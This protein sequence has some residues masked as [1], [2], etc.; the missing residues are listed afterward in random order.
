MKH[1]HSRLLVATFAALATVIAVPTWAQNIAVVN[2]RP[3]PKAKA[4]EIIQQ[5]TKQGQADTPELEAK[6]KESLITRELLMQEIDK[7]GLIGDK[8]VQDKLEQ[9]R[10]QILIQALAQSYFKANPPSDA[11]ARVA[12]DTMAK[13]MSPKEY[14]A[15]HI[16]VEKESEAKAIIAK[17]K[18]GAKFEDLAKQ[19]KDPG[20]AANGGDLDWAP[21]NNYVAPFS[22]ALVKLQKGHYT[23]TPVKTQFGWH[24]IRLDDV[25]DAK[26]PTFEEAKPQVVQ[27]M[28]Q[29]QRWEQAKFAEFVESLKAKAKIE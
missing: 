23:E 6:V 13:S 21:P 25:R 7:R 5:V 29:D 22:D 2:G 28:M 3:I 11:D 14:R 9:A 19:S 4:D 24:V 10:V 18:A 16:L 20:S 15:R 1:S 26:L 8:E 27:L 12:Y 17:L